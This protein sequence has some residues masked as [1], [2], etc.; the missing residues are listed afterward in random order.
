MYKLSALSHSPNAWDPCGVSAVF[1]TSIRIH[2]SA[3]AMSSAIATWTASS[4]SK[5]A[6]VSIS[7]LGA[8]PRPSHLT[9][10]CWE[11]FQAYMHGRSSSSQ[12]S[13]LQ[14][15]HCF[16]FSRPAKLTSTGSI[17]SLVLIALSLLLPLLRPDYEGSRA[18]KTNLYRSLRRAAAS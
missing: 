2:G 9:L 16:L 4:A 18:P 14:L 7:Q 15:V 17:V 10:R 3:M 1:I 5:Q 6:N 13:D 8:W 12:Y 11:W